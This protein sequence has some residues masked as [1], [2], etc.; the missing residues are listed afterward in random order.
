MKYGNEVLKNV[1]KPYYKYKQE[2]YNS[3]R[4]L[5]IS[6]SGKRGYCL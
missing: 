2:A 1:V 5:A 3:I 6:R 4:G